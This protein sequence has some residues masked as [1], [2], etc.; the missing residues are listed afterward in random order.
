VV[1][2]QYQVYK[3]FKSTQHALLPFTTSGS[4]KTLLCV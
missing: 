2:V 1:T 3:Q 4:V